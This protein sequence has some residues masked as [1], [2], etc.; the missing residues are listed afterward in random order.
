MISSRVNH[1][2]RNPS[3]RDRRDRSS[4]VSHPTTSHSVRRT[5]RGPSDR[6]LCRRNHCAGWQTRGASLCCDGLPPR[7][8]CLRERDPHGIRRRESRHEN[9]FRQTRRHAPPQPDWTQQSWLRTI[10]RQRHRLEPARTAVSSECSYPFPSIT[11]FAQAAFAF[12]RPDQLW[13]FRLLC[14]PSRVS[15]QMFLGKIS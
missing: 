6:G 13:R 1:S 12:Q 9:L 8:A 10:G 11:P 14:V 5:V 2:R 7:Q 4:P 15:S 3:H